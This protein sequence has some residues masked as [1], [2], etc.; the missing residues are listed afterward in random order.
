MRHIRYIFTILS[1]LLL[2]T[3]IRAE[4]LAI[5]TGFATETLPEKNMNS[6]LKY[7]KLV[8]IKRIGCV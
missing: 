5:D 7:I 6:F 8:L 3:Y 2:L 4:V 1:V